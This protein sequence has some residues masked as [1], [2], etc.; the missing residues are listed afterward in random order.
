M[1][2]GKIMF[3]PV[4]NRKV[5]EVVIEQIKNMVKTGELKKGDKLPPERDLVEQL[6]VS[7]TSIR[8][9][10]RALEILGLIECKQGEGNFVRKSFQ[11]SLLEPLSIMFML[12]ESTP[13]EVIELRRILEI[14]TASL[15]AKHIKQEKLTEI[16]N[17]V[18]TFK[19]STDEKLNTELDQEFHFKIAEASENFLLVNVLTTVSSIIDS[20]ISNARLRIMENR[21]NRE[22]LIQQHEAVYR[23]LCEHDSKSAAEEMKKHLEFVSKTIFNE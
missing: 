7:R 8:E 23:A 3:T 19:N 16:Y 11:Q 21:D 4:K 14:E 15:A 22:I 12:Q 9:A 1:H 10:I 17:I 5:Y 18:D 6:K 20:F 13:K 2:G